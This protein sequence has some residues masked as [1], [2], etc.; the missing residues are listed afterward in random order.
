MIPGLWPH[1]VSPFVILSYYIILSRVCQPFFEFFIN[2]FHQIFIRF[3]IRFFIYFLYLSFIVHVII[4]LDVSAISPMFLGKTFIGITFLGGFT[5]MKKK[6][7]LIN[8]PI[9]SSLT[10]L[11]IPIMA[12]SLIQMAYNMID[13]IWIGRLGSSAVAS[14]GAAG[15]YMW[16][17]NGLV[18]LTR[19]GG[20]VHVGHAIGSGDSE[21]AGHYGSTAFQM[22]ILLGILYGLLCIFAA[23]PLIS[24]FHLNSPD[25]INDAVSYLM[26][27]CGLIIFSF[28]NQIFTGLFTAIGNSHPA[29]L[30]T[31]AGLFINIILDP[32][33]IFGIGPFPALNVAGA[34]LATVLAQMI[35]TLL[36]LFFALKDNILFHQI[37]LFRR[38]DFNL[39]ASILRLGLPSCLQSLVFTGISMIVAR[40]V[41]GY[42]DA[43]VAVQKVGAQIESISWMTSDGFSSAVNS[44]IAQNHGARKEDRIRAG[45]RC[46]LK[47]VLPWGLF[48]TILLIVFPVP[49]FKIFITEPDVI[50]MGIS[51]LMILGISQLFSSLEIMTS[52]AFCGYGKTLPPSV[53]GITLNIMR[54]PLALILTATPLGL[55]GI[56]W[57]ISISSILKGII[58][59]IWFQIM[60][61]KCY[62]YK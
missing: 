26:I 32:I 13:M 18:T 49:I 40:L 42:G 36:F 24:F 51:Y 8:G 15:M 56:W 14:I 37:H 21:L 60:L 35:V 22:T 62:N 28:L 34:A 11:A 39:A 61:K 41:A 57:S 7:D 43:A 25:V 4:L 6:I 44:F 3:F 27:T 33:L 12:T 30:S 1:V 59:F 9:L 20:Q 55:N 45:Y 2:I 58:L 5:I 19:M 52:G 16:L 29:F 38:L 17:A 50:P 31:S 48:C 47:I 46:A 54:I 10:R 53:S 23:K